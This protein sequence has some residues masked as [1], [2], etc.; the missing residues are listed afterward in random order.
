M[1]GFYVSGRWNQSGRSERSLFG[2]RTRPGN[3][4]GKIPKRPS[5]IFGFPSQPTQFLS[6]SVTYAYTYAFTYAF[7]Y[8]YTYAFTYTSISVTH[9]LPQR[10][11]QSM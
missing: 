8:A 11:I 4:P 2:S 10:R 6:I 7:T 1:A 3:P 5:D 9:Y